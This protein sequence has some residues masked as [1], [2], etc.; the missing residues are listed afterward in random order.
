MLDKVVK[1]LKYLFKC[2]INKHIYIICFI[3]FSILAVNVNVNINIESL[4]LNI[5]M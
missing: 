3:C 5:F 1:L 2:N 4:H